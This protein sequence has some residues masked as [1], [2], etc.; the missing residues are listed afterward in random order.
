MMWIVNLTRQACLS[1]DANMAFAARR[2]LAACQSNEESASTIK[3]RF[4][5]ACHIAADAFI[6]IA[7]IQ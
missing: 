4:L 5:W 1:V 6:W 2:L 3:Q 7:Q